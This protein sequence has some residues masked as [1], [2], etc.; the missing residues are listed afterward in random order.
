MSSEERVKAEPCVGG[1]SACLV[2]GDAAE[3]ARE[4]KIKRRAIGISVVLESAGLAVLVIAPLFAKTAQLNER[5][6][7]PV[8]PYR[9]VPV[10]RQSGQPPTGTTNHRQTIFTAPTSIAPLIHTR[11]DDHP[12]ADPIT[13]GT[14]PSLTGTGST[15]AIEMGDPRRQPPP[16]I[17]PPRATGRI[18][19]PRIDPAL[20]TRRIEPKYPP[21]A[22]DLHKSGRVEL[23][24]II[25]TDGS[26]ESLEVVS[27]DPLF[28]NSARQAVLQ[29]RYRPTYLNG[30]AVEVDTYISVIYT[31][32]P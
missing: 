25:G 5:V 29:W 12:L 22:R 1:F 4:R 31:L 10:Q 11:D 9:N 28:I 20:L 3:R 2:D 6:V 24:A 26:V 32:T 14:V 27:G 7:L 17:E 16:P 13:E 15:G 19:E 23:R 21:L 8:P 30:R 18:Q